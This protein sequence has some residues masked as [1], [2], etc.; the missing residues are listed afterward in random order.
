MLL[1]SYTPPNA[2]HITA[3]IDLVKKMLEDSLSM[4]TVENIISDRRTLRH[5]VLVS[6]VNF[7]KFYEYAINS[8]NSYKILI[9]SFF[10]LLLACLVCSRIGLWK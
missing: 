2:D 6:R 9:N 1:A 10:F 3:T 5:E 8:S 7:I 4:R